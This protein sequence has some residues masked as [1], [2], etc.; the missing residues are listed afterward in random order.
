MGKS[1]KVIII[2]DR[3]VA[4]NCSPK[5]E[6]SNTAQLL[7]P[8]LDGLEVGG[9]K[10]DL[11]Y[12]AKL[13]INPCSGRFICW[14]KT[15]GECKWDD[16]M[17]KVYPKLKE[18]QIWV[19]STPVYVDG[20]TGQMK[21]LLDRLIPLVKPFFET[22]DDH[23]RHPPRDDNMGEKVVLI[24]TCGFWEMDNFDPL[25]T[26]ME[27]FCRNSGM[28]FGGALLRPHGGALRK[29]KEMGI[30]PEDIFKAAR[31]AGRQLATE[32]KMSK[33][34]LETVSREILPKDEYIELANKY[35]EET[36]EE[37]KIADL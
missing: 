15:P 21:I 32:G 10:T 28:D 6:K 3:A 24:S 35:F 31:D 11:F 34:T 12:T 30:E 8:F 2:T 23:C 33:E 20:I 19:F 22:R 18:S 16:D 29:M 5:A 13:D 1:R 17:E 26:H 37:R 7:N 9:V 27:A 36:L 14:T 4:F 25:I